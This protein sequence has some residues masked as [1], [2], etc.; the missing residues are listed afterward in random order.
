MRNISI[1]SN[2]SLSST[3]FALQ[4]SHAIWSLTARLLRSILLP[5]TTNGK[6]SASRGHAWMRNSSRQLSRV[7]NVFGTVTS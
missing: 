6:C 1:N 2:C 3:W 7:L 4:E 5:M